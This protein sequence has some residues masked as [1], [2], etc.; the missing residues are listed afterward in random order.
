M[1]QEV[2]QRNTNSDK[3]NGMNSTLFVLIT[4]LCTMKSSST[5]H[6]DLNESVHVID[7]KLQSILNYDDLNIRTM[8][9]GRILE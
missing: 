4:I 9:S 7:M 6:I 2:P 3:K 1:N 8:V 5:Q